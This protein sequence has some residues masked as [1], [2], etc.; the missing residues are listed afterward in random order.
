MTDA[1][2]SNRVILVTDHPMTLGIQFLL[3]HLLLQDDLRSQFELYGLVASHQRFDAIEAP[4]TIDEERA[5]RSFFLQARPAVIGLSSI[6]RCRHRFLAFLRGLRTQLPDTVFV[7][8]G[9]DAI[10]SH[11]VY[12]D[13]GVDLVAVGDG[14]EPMAALLR[15]LARACGRLWIRNHPPSGLASPEHPHAEPA[16]SPVRM[17]LPYFGDRLLML[18][19]DGAITPIDDA[20][21]RPDHV[22]FRHR[23]SAFDMYTQ[24]G[25]THQCSFC[26]QDLLAVY[27]NNSRRNARRQS[28]EHVVEHLDGLRRSYPSRDYVYFWDLDF[29]R[30]PRAE[31]LRFAEE[32]RERVGLPFFIFVTEKTV[33]VA[34]EEVIR[35][36]VSAGL[37]SINMG[38]QSGSERI[39]RDVFNRHCTPAESVSAI[40][41]LHAATRN[42]PVELLY[43]VITYTPEETAEDV[44]KTIAVIRKIPTD[45]RQAVRL[46]THKL[47]Y[48]T[49]QV[50]SSLVASHT[51]R[52][53]Q[54]FKSDLDYLR[55]TS[56]PYLSWLVGQMMRG[57]ITPDYVG[58]IRR[59]RIDA[60]IA[61]EMV[62]HMERSKRFASILY[63]AIASQDRIDS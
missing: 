49:G 44:L 13:A 14:E 51:T 33:N 9:I 59:D 30:R 26:A 10:T 35:A 34:G 55:Q 29:L 3:D 20:L 41:T 39:L 54:D 28:L 45:G 47:S 50:L 43:D 8:G 18:A 27:R 21:G 12:F 53:Y 48:N 16:E 60:L 7:A 61:D 62:Q 6:E 4:F 25:C 19:T 15:E 32:Y 56:V 24:R 2:T 17:P 46:S 63:E 5:L 38:I 1:R 23:S 37:H 22:Q 11:R 31:L 40:E 57:K 42:D 36:L 58:H 52:D